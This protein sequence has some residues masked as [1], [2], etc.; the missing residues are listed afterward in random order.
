MNFKEIMSRITGVSTPIFGVSWT[1]PDLERNQIRSLLISLEDKRILGSLW[2]MPRYLKW[3]I[4]SVFNIRNEITDCLRNNSFHD[5]TEN[6][7][8]EMRK[9]CRFL[10][11]ATEKK[12]IKKLNTLDND[13]E[14]FRISS[15]NCVAKLCV[16]YGLDVEENLEWSIKRY[17]NT[18]AEQ[19]V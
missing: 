8:R 5:E 14:I 18:E 10:L 9:N 1:P 4:D 16:I 11:D 7:L 19:G 17:V 2:E 12:D 6:I 15:A 3:A 13:F